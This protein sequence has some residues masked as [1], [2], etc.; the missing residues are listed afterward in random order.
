MEQQRQ[1]NPR[2]IDEI[3]IKLFKTKEKKIAYI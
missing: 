1:R 3:K 2:T